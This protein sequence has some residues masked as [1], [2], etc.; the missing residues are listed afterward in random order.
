MICRIDK[1]DM[2]SAYKIHGFLE[3]VQWLA[4]LYCEATLKRRK[5]L[6]RLDLR[7][8]AYSQRVVN[9]WTGIPTD[10]VTAL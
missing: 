7:K 10:L 9:K 1:G 8:F 2:I 4:P 6:S 5:D 3:G